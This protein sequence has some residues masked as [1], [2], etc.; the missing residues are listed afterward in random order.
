MIDANQLLYAYSQGLFPMAIPEEDDAIA[1]FQPDMRGIIPL[2]N[3]HIPKNLKRLYRKKPF[4]LRINSNFEGVIRACAERD[5]TWISEEL[6]LSYLQ[7]HQL[8]HAHS[9]ECWKDNEL[10]G[11]LYGVAL[12]EAFFGESMF[13]HVTDASKIALVFLIEFLNEHHF[14]LLDTQYINDHLL[15]F[16]AI[17]IPQNEYEVLLQNALGDLGTTDQADAQ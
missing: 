3:Y 7:L 15:Q 9:F 16:G 10:V 2:D 17:E 5:S 13:H 6:I 4:D 14:K 8:G 1:W 11:G 12:H